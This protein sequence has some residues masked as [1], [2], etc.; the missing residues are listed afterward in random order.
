MGKKL[1]AK[2]K[3]RRL[4]K[5]RTR[6]YKTKRFCIAVLVLTIGYVLFRQFQ[7]RLQKAEFHRAEGYIEELRL[8]V[9]GYQQTQLQYTTKTN[10]CR[11]S[12]AEFG[13]GRRNCSVG[14]KIVYPNISL[15]SA[16]RGLK[17]ISGLAN[18]GTLV[19]SSQSMDIV[20]TKHDDV[21]H[22]EQNLPF[23]S[24]VT[25][26]TCSASYV[27]AKSAN[28]GSTDLGDFTIYLICGGS[29]LSEYYETTY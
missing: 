12:S 21:N 20:F 11:Y 1:S 10:A 24:R 16:N 28:S 4:T 26:I 15:D 8:K 23:T 25:D 29:A 3:Q 19:T 6:L 2:P 13:H 22:V 14:A 18:G 27:Y 17:K 5:Q 9:N 7:I